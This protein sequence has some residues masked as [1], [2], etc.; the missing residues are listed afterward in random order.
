MLQT[1]SEALSYIHSLNRFGSVPGLSRI[2][3]LLERLGNPQ[4]KLKFVHVAGTNGKGSTVAMTANILKTAGYKTG[5]YI[6]PYVLE[7]RERIQINSKMIPEEKL[8]TITNQIKDI[9]DELLKNGEII[10]EFEV[11]TAIAMC[12][13]CEKNCDI[14]C[15]EVGLGGRFDATN[16][17]DAP[18]IGVITAISLDHTEVLGD[19]V[20]KITR[21]KCGI[22]KPGSIT[23]SY[24]LQDPDALAVIMET[25]SKNKSELVMGNMGSVEILSDRPFRTEILYDSLSLTISLAGKHQIANTVTVVEIV[26]QLRRLGYS[27]SDTDIKQGIATT[28]FPARM[29]ILS[30]HPLIVLDAAHNLAGA[31]ALADMLEAFK[32]HEITIIIGMLRDKDYQGVLHKLAGF[33]SHIYTVTPQSPRALPAKELAATAQPLC[34]DVRSFE[35]YADAVKAA[36]CLDKENSLTVICGSLYLAGEMRKIVKDSLTESCV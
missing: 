16:V 29:E 28:F 13:F 15:L 5:M 6:S 19:S 20:E 12:W 31:C 33:A 25:C 11:V 34:S 26:K 30:Q 1:Y 22:L 21:E 24:P 36:L 14:V 8:L 4:K 7:F 9:C 3:H 23:V 35:H 2:R 27:I 17:I 10:T 18:L 32:D